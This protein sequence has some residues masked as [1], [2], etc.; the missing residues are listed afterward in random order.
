VV[1]LDTLYQ[2]FEERDGARVLS[3]CTFCFRDSEDA[4]YFGR[5]TR[6]KLDL[7]PQDF[8]KALARIPD[9]EIYPE[10][11]PSATIYTGTISAGLYIKNVKLRDYED[12]AGTDYLARLCRAEVQ[13]HELLRQ[14][15]HQ[16]IVKYHGCIVKRGRVVGMVLD[17]YPSTLLER[18]E[19]AKAG[20][21]DYK[22]CMAAIESGVK[23]LHSLGLAHNDLNPSNIMLND[24]DVPI[25][26]DLGSCR[27]FGREL[28]A[29]GTVG[30]IDGDMDTYTTSEERH[31]ESAILKIRAWIE[32]HSVDKPS[33]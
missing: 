8:S 2:V 14:H 12:F 30:W 18:I 24:S 21:L 6:N 22:S 29:G 20:S 5:S 13:I 3:H 10:L 19:D 17:R 32:E 7:T 25:I 27:P 23:H 1:E 33:V 28:L 11:P 26:I 9:H 31:D 16:H 4:A 15:P